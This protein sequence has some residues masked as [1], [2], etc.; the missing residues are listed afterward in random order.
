MQQFE[1]ASEAYERIVEFYPELEQYKLHYAQCL[2]KSGLTSEATKVQEE[3]SISVAIADV[4]FVYTAIA[5]AGVVVVVFPRRYGR[6]DPLFVGFPAK[7][8][9]DAC[10]GHI[11][12]CV[13]MRALHSMYIAFVRSLTRKC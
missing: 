2:F 8:K 13:F 1:S 5:F 12:S 11:H 10:R 9:Y 4:I 7:H 3:D 6:Q